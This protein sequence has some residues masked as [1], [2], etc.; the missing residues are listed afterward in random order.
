MQCRKC[1]QRAIQPML[2]PPSWDKTEYQ[3]LMQPIWNQAVTQLKNATRICIIGYSLPESDAYFKYLLTLGLAENHGLYKFIVVDLAQRSFNLL[4]A[5]DERKGK[6]KTLRE[7]YGELLEDLFQERRF[8]FHQEGL[9][10]WMQNG[11]V[12]RDLGRGEAIVRD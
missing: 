7:R 4:D 2:V 1:Q 9:W 10:Q 12:L 11:S 5:E 6:P 8:A 3:N